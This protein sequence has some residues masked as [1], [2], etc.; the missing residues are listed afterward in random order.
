[1][2]RPDAA[3]YFCRDAGCRL[4]TS[5]EWKAL[6]SWIERCLE[7]ARR[8]LGYGCV[9][10]AARTATPPNLGMFVPEGEKPTAEIWMKGKPTDRAGRSGDRQYDDGVLWFKEVAPTTSG[11]SAAFNNLVG[12]VAEMCSRMGACT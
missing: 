2:F 5:G 1:M 9:G 12:N 4:P 11:G 7:F 6:I 3:N 10:F 8:T